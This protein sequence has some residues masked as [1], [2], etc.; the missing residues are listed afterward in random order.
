MCISVCIFVCVYFSVCG[1]VWFSVCVSLCVYL[2]L[3]FSLCVYLCVCVYLSV[4]CM[5]LQTSAK[6]PI[7]KETIE[8]LRLGLKVSDLLNLPADH[9]F[10]IQHLAQFLANDKFIRPLSHVR[11][12][13]KRV[14]FLSFLF[15]D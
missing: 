11:Y 2:Y 3:W 10:T 5:F 8:D 1:S 6:I 13:H 7:K 12:V 14:C 15:H 9:Q 4:C